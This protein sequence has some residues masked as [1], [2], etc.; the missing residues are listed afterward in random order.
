MPNNLFD[1]FFE[2]FLVIAIFMFFVSPYKEDYHELQLIVILLF[3]ENSSIEK[4]R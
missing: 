1:F 2:M 4:G 3:F